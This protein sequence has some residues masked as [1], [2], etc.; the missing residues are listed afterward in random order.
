MMFIGEN[1]DS[2]INTV[3]QSLSGIRI[4]FGYGSCSC[5]YGI[6]LISKTLKRKAQLFSKICT[7]SVKTHLFFTLCA[8]HV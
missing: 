2:A 6:L 7:V 4:Y 8:I 3:V 5:L 1:D